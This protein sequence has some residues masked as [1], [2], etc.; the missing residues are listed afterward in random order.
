MCTIS[1][2]LVNNKHIIRLTY[3]EKLNFICKHIIHRTCDTPPPLPNIL[4]TTALGILY[5]IT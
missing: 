5:F 4:Q 3:S 2:F 1:R